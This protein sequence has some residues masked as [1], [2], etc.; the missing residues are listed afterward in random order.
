MKRLASSLV[1]VL[2]LDSSS[3]AVTQ[4]TSNLSTLQPTAGV[5]PSLANEARAAI[6]R[7]T[8]WLLA[9]QNEDGH[10]SSADYPALTALPLWALL[11]GG[12][13]EGDAVERAT[14]FILGTVNEDGSICREPAEKKK[15]GGLCNY[16]TALCMVALH[17][18]GDPVINTQVLK[19]RHYLAGS[20]HFGSDVYHGGMGYDA[21]NDRPYADLSNSYMSYEAMRLTQDLEDLRADGDKPADLDWAAARQFVSRVQNLPGSND[22]PWASDAPEE[23]GGFAYDPTATKAGTYTNE[24]GK[25]V[26]RSY[27]SMTYAGLLSFIYANVDKSDERVTSAFDWASKHW[28]LEENPGMGSEGQYYFYNVVA[29]ALASYG[30]DVIT[31]ADERQINWRNELIR[32]LVNLQKIDAKSGAGY[33]VNEAN[34]WMEADPVL[35]TSYTLLAL[36]IALGD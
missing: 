9:Q 32:K 17:A 6:Q 2:V 8:D 16:N 31:L 22:Q 18:L 15:G 11:K 12:V 14:K 20:Q 24:S 13:T 7:G 3:P 28:T 34:R 25:I 33:W 27:G 35:V 23:R 1:L 26:L 36:E 21:E 30:Q 4:E 5:D 29:K 19:A 10:W